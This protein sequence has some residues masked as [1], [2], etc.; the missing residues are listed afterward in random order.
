MRSDWPETW[1]IECDYMRSQRK[2]P[3]AICI[4][5]IPHGT[6][7]EQCEAMARRMWEDEQDEE[8]DFED[9]DDPNVW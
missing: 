6:F 1:S 9:E 4:H 8:D 7:C 2:K 5:E 3:L